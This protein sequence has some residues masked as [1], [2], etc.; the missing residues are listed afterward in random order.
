MYINF[1]HS[2]T[3]TVLQITEIKI[4]QSVVLLSIKSMLFHIN[5]RH[6]DVMSLVHVK[7]YDS[8]FRM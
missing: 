3:C 5:F 1:T 7:I 4:R 2:H 6:H 8:A